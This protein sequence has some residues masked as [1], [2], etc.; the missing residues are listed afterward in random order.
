MGTELGARGVD[1]DPPLW[2]ARAIDW[3]P[4]LIADL[5]REY[6]EAGATVHTTNTFRT[7]RRA[8]RQWRELAL[9][10]V[11]I[12]RVAV[13]NGHRIAASISPLEDCYRP[14]L[15]PEDP[16]PEHREL[17]ELLAP[18][19][20]LFLCETFPHA[21]EAAVAVEEAARSKV[22]TWV[23]FT[24]GPYGTLMTPE[25]MRDAARACIERGAKAVLVNCVAA[26]ATLPYVKALAG[27]GVPFGA[28]ANSCETAALAPE[29]YAARARSWFEAGA[30]IVG[31]CCG[32]DP[33]HIRALNTIG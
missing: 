7:K 24:A 16:R 27:L 23:S 29:D 15:S 4:G 11:R 33:A 12:A 18:K 30:T 31:G 5:H 32:T 17:I 10:A 3:T 22:E 20:D 6:A 26:D 13:P 19:V 1:L 21:G 14:D 9:E 8:T 2:S 28:Y 25:Q